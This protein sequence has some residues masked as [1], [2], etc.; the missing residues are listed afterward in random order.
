MTVAVVL[1]Q[2]DPRLPRLLGLLRG[3]GVPLRVEYSGGWVLVGYWSRAV[4]RRC[5]YEQ[6]LEGPEL[7]ACMVAESRLLASLVFE[8]A[9][10]LGLEPP[11]ECPLCHSLFA[12]PRDAGR[13]LQAHLDGLDEGVSGGGRRGGPRG[14]DSWARVGGGLP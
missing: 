1:G 10:R 6:G 9:R 5:R 3:M 7:R 11:L 14:L 8:A 4:W 12:T 2:G 13:H